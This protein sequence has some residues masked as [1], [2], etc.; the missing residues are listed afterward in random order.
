MKMPAALRED[1]WKT[2]QKV[3]T[4]DILTRPMCM[5][6]PKTD[7]ALCVVEAILCVCVCVCTMYSPIPSH[8]IDVPKKLSV[9]A[10]W[11]IESFTDTPE[12]AF[13]MKSISSRGSSSLCG[14]IKILHIPVN[15]IHKLLF[16]YCYCLVG[17]SIAKR[18]WLAKLINLQVKG[19]RLMGQGLA[20]SFSFFFFDWPVYWSAIA[21]ENNEYNCLHTLLCLV[22]L[23][24]VMCAGNCPQVYC[25]ALVGPFHLNPSLQMWADCVI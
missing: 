19:I 10:C 17:F 20:P 14:L 21:S 12:W 25:W 11:C 7:I 4:S 24:L 5:Y 8:Q 22:T 3:S 9:L 13:S 1:T 15:D 18:E 16:S 2:V 23:P 6:T